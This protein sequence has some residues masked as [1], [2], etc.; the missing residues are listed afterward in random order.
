[1]YSK[2]NLDDLI[3]I[4]NFDKKLFSTDENFNYCKEKFLSDNNYFVK[5]AVLKKNTKEILATS[6]F[7]PEINKK[8]NLYFISINNDFYK[9]KGIGSKLLIESFNFMFKNFENLNEILLFSR[10]DAYNFY[11]KIKFLI[12]DND[13]DYLQ[14]KSYKNIFYEQNKENLIWH[15]LQ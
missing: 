3:F 6:N 11:K 14:F 7:S 4:A 2:T 12:N 8:S 13:K 9:E 15:E 10:G 1:M 5:F